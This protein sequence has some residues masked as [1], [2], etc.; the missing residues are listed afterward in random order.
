MA[1]ADATIACAIDNGVLT[2]T[3]Q[4]FDPIQIDPTDYPNELVDYAALHGFKQRYTDAAALGAGS[5]PAEKHAAIMAL[6]THHRESGEWSR[7]GAAGSGAGGDGLLVRAV[8]EVFGIDRDTA[9]TQV[10]AMDKKTQAG[11]RASPELA[12]I[13]ARLRVEKA[14]RVTVDTAKAV[15]NAMNT[16]R[17]MAPALM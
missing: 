8:M 14:P 15:A 4:G 13:I 12:P 16:L 9:R 10:G 17:N 1:R 5:T 11:L 6:V 2:I 7:V 3:V